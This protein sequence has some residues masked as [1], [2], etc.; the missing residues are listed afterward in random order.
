M[1]SYMCEML[2]VSSR[3]R[4]GQTLLH[5]FLHFYDLNKV[6]SASYNIAVRSHKPDTISL[7]E[8]CHYGDLSVTRNSNIYFGLHVKCLIF[9]HN[10]NQ[11]LFFSTD[12]LKSLKYKIS[13]KSIQPILRTEGGA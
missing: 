11:I 6:G 13:Q 4:L 8:N 9:L 5:A 3:T 2:C 12:F 10:F 1:W 7:E